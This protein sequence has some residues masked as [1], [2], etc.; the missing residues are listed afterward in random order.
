MPSARTASSA[1]S[2]QADREARAKEK[3]RAD[4]AHDRYVR[5]TYGL[6][7][8]EYAAI[9]AAQD[10]RCAICTRRPRS[11]RL[12]VDHDHETGKVRGLLCYTCNHF[13]LGFVEFDPIAAHN[14]ATYIGG[15]ARDYGP[16]Y[17][18]F[19]SAQPALRDPLVEARRT[20]GRVMPLPVKLPRLHDDDLPF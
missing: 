12:A 17:D 8:G 4:R 1:S 10:G 14:A 11:R 9:L 18:P 20:K 15:I 5:R 13:V 6:T 7:E 3:A 19:P 16:A 2:R